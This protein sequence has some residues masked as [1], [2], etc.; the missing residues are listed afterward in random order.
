MSEYDIRDLDYLISEYPK[1]GRGLEAAK[2]EIKRLRAR[3]HPDY[4]T[5]NYCSVCS[6]K[7]LGYCRC[8]IACNE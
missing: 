7:G 4:G 2:N 1:I 5:P 3:L 6:P 8:E